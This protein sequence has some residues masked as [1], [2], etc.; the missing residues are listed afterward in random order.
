MKPDKQSLE[1][2]EQQRE[3]PWAYVVKKKSARFLN[4]RNE[5]EVQRFYCEK[6]NQ[7]SACMLAGMTHFE[8]LSSL[9][10]LCN[11]NYMSTVGAIIKRNFKIYYLIYS[12]NIYQ[13]QSLSDI[14]ADTVLI[15]LI[16]SDIVLETALCI[17]SRTFKIS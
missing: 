6:D 17:L 9:A 14:V 11:N 10:E 15:L 4:V 13:R 8:P 12:R 7:G 5:A 16:A 2:T 3:K 1:K